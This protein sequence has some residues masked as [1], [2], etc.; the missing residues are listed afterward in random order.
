M[1]RRRLVFATPWV[2]V[3]SCKRPIET[4]REA[5]EEVGPRALSADAAA[6]GTVTVA[7]HEAPADAQPD[8]PVDAFDRE[9]QRRKDIR[10]AEI[11][12]ACDP[13]NVPDP[14]AP[15]CNPPSPQ[16]VVGRVLRV[17]V[18]GSY[19]VVELDVGE[20]R[21]LKRGVTAEVIDENA[22][23][24]PGGRCQI[25]RVDK[26]STVCSVKLTPDQVNANPR[27][28]LRFE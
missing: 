23:P 21:G 24:V 18:S 16:P 8:A 20:D 19:T 10:M 13:R 5:P 12:R 28:R 9:A 26:H 11:P 25:I 2:I 14:D 7:I 4:H 6:A 15:H 1:K 22:R 17:Q 3:A 27:V